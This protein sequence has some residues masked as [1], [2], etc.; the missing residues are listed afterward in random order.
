MSL[1]SPRLQQSPVRAASGGSRCCDCTSFFFNRSVYKPTRKSKRICCVTA[2]DSR[3]E[4]SSVSRIRFGSSKL[5]GRRSEMEDDVVVRSDG[6]GKFTYAAVF[7]GHAGFS[8]MEFL[9]FTDTHSILLAY[10]CNFLCYL[11]SLL[12][13]L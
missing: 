5:Q 13:C 2:V 1:L 3:F 11:S 4:L 8:S 12:K 7:D 9:R 10:F 6:L